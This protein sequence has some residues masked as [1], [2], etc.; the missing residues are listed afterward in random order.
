[1]AV[2]PLDHLGR[3]VLQFKRQ[4]AGNGEVQGAGATGLTTHQPLGITLPSQEFANDGR[5][6]LN[7]RRVGQAAALPERARRAGHG[8]GDGAQSGAATLGRVLAGHYGWAPPA[9]QPAQ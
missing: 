1:M 9:R 2:D 4:R 6:L 5:P 3:Q 7:Q 8:G